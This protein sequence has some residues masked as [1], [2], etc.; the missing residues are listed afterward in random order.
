LLE[1]IPE[2]GRP[3]LQPLGVIPGM[4]PSRITDAP[5]CTFANRCSLVSADCRRPPVIPLKDHGN[6][7]A[8]RCIL[9]PP[10]RAD[11]LR[12]EFSA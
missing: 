9:P 1:C 3:R 5:G 7:R 11:A 6:G 8:S 10:I 2:P 4:V 12:A